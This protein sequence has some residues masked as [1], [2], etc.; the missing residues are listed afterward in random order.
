MSVVTMMRGVHAVAL[1]FILWCLIRSHGSDFAPGRTGPGLI[2]ASLVWLGA[3]YAWREMQIWIPLEET[4]VPLKQGQVQS[5]EFEIKL[6]GFYAIGI[7]PQEP[8][9]HG[10][11]ASGQTDAQ[12]HWVPVGGYLGTFHACKGRYV[13]RVTPEESPAVPRTSA[14]PMPFYCSY[15]FSWPTCSARFSLRSRGRSS[16]ARRR[17]GHTPSLNLARKDQ[18][19]R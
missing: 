9:Q 6:E 15:R 19:H 8:W 18:R 11:Y 10:E 12:G 17:R 2:A 1:L 14:S 16:D 13:L 3:C 4:P 7:S 5:P